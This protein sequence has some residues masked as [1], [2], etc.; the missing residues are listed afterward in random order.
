MGSG[1]TSG[2]NAPTPTRP[3]ITPVQQ[4]NIDR[5]A[6]LGITPGQ[7]F[8]YSQLTNPVYQNFTPSILQGETLSTYK[9]PPLATTGRYKS[10]T[11]GN[12]TVDMWMPGKGADYKNFKNYYPFNKGTWETSKIP[13]VQVTAPAPAP[14]SAPYY[15]KDPSGAV[16]YAGE[17]GAKGTTP[18]YDQA[19]RIVGYK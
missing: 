12:R 16:P 18:V 8:T 11:V 1:G 4:Y 14:V 5:S 15:I 9:A 7:R 19:G 2:G 17:F 13:M 6:A 10:F 3:G